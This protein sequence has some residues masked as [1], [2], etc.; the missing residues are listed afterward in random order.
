M[1]TSSFIITGSYDLIFSSPYFL[2]TF[3]NWLVYTHKNVIL[4][5]T[6]VKT[7]IL[8]LLQSEW[9]FSFCSTQCWCK[10]PK[11]QEK[12]FSFFLCIRVDLMKY[13]KR[14]H[15]SVFNTTSAVTQVTKKKKK[16]EKQLLLLTEP[17]TEKDIALLK[18]IQ[19]TVFSHSQRFRLCKSGCVS[20]SSHD[21]FYAWRKWHICLTK[22]SVLIWRNSLHRQSNLSS[23]DTSM[24]LRYVLLDK[25]TFFQRKIEETSF[26][27]ALYTI[28]ERAASDRVE[29]KITSEVKSELVLAVWELLKVGDG[30]IDRSNVVSRNISDSYYKKK[31]LEKFAL[32]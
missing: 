19:F 9:Q 14:N 28:G 4:Q 18:K 5:Q 7:C 1:I 15:S 25:S 3:C 11:L 32:E 17:L 12:K 30:D 22:R 29:T 6:F 13:M 23:F 2:S 31:T 8:A 20:F 27:C 10:A 26:G 21:Q 24:A 16:K